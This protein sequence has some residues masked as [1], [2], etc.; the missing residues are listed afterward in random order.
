MDAPDL[1]R[2]QSIETSSPA[3]LVA[4]LYHAAVAA[5]ARAKTALSAGDATGAH[6]DLV[7]AQDIVHELRV[8]L[9][10]ERGGDVAVSLA[11]LYDWCYDQ[12]VLANTSKSPVPLTSVESVLM[13]LAGSWD[14]ML[15]GELHESGSGAM[16][17][18]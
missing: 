15:V 4:M 13:Q 1:Y 16:A 18:G 2:Q 17:V 11:S 5:T 9:D 10:H 3:Q 7:R 8:T 12:L 6:A 14:E